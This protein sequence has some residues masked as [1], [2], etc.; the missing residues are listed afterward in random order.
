MTDLK[1]VSKVCFF[2]FT[3]TFSERVKIDFWVSR[4]L[5]VLY[6]TLKTYNAQ[7]HIVEYLTNF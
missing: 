7:N 2:N 5:E 6:Q 3:I 4:D 1:I